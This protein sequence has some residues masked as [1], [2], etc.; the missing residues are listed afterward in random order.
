MDIQKIYEELDKL[1]R[2]KSS[3]EFMSTTYKEDMVCISG[4]YFILDDISKQI[5]E[6]NEAINKALKSG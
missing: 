2:L 3:V 4:A 6:V 1:D 5:Q